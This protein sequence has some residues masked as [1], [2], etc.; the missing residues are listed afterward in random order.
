MMETA[1]SIRL[2]PSTLVLAETAKETDGNNVGTA[3]MKVDVNTAKAQSSAMG[4]ENHASWPVLSR[5]PV[6]LEVGVPVMRF[7]V[8]DVLALELGKVIQTTWH[9]TAD[10]PLK[11]GNVH[12]SWGEFEV[13]DG[14]LAL[15]LTV[16]A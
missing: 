3:E 12:L 9:G 10:I 15:R 7:C 13:A 4:Y 11:A 1:E 5:L 2:Q 16:L 14:K 6:M 8:R